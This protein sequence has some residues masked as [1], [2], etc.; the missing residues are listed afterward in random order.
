MTRDPSDAPIQRE[1]GLTAARV[2]EFLTEHPD[3]LNQ[4]PEVLARMSA[5]ARELGGPVVDLQQAMIERDRREIRRLKEKKRDLVGTSRENLTAQSQIPDCVLALL[6]ANSFAQ[7]IQI[8]N[9][10]RVV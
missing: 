2:M 3:F 1:G 6:S 9:T 7:L 4:H 8:I 10:K 5:P